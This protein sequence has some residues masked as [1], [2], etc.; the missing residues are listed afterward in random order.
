MRLCE[1]MREQ[2]EEKQSFI[3]VSA[4][5]AF[6]WFHHHT[7]YPIPENPCTCA[8]IFTRPLHPPAITTRTADT[9]S[10]N[11]DHRHHYYHHAHAAA[12]VLHH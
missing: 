2:R 7:L 1:I 10:A 11:T 9:T 3:A 6:Q 12:A 4:H 8:A 5:F